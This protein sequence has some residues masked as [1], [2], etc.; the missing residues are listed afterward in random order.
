MG[1]DVLVVDDDHRILD[2]VVGYS[3]AYGLECVAYDSGLEALRFLKSCSDDELPRAYI[4]DMR[5]DNGIEELNSHVYIFE[6]LKSKDALENFCF[7]TGHFSPHDTYIQDITQARV[8]I[9]GRGEVMNFLK[10]LCD[11]KY[12]G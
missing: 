9:K 6:Y 4:V 10:S 7:F 12:S 5:I 1:I 8:I 2:V 3:E 11:P